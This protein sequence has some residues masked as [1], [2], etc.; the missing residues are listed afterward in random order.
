[1]MV[2]ILRARLKPEM[3]KVYEKRWA[4]IYARGSKAP[5]FISANQFTAKDGEIACL[6]EFDNEENLNAW[7]NDAEALLVQEQ[8]RD[9]FFADFSAQICTE[10]RRS[11]SKSTRKP[12]AAAQPR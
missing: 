6:M 10:V 5:G 1:M 9:Q 8:G 12:Q 3:S 7:K 4:E 11:G 2:I